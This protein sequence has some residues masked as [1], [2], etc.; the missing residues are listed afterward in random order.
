MPDL[1]QGGATV[2]AARRRVSW[3]RL[4][5]AVVVVALAVVI[6]KTWSRTSASASAASGAWFAPYVDLTLTPP[7]EFDGV[8]MRVFPLRANMEQVQSFIDAYLNVAP[9]EVAHFQTFLPYV[10]LMIIN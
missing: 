10:Y 6:V 5:L 2:S 8:M 4:L 3:G 7:F 9:K 1:P